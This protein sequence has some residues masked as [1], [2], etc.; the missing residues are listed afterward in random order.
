MNICKLNMFDYVSFRAC[1]KPLRK[2]DQLTLDIP[3][4][5]TDVFKLPFFVRI[6]RLRNALPLSIYY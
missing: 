5:R 2:I 6:C 3:F 4:S 1:N